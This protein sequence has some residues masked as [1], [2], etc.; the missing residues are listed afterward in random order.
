MRKLAS[1]RS[2]QCGGS[3]QTK[4]GPTPILVMGPPSSSYHEALSNSLSPALDTQ[5]ERSQ[6]MGT[7]Q[8]SGKM[9]GDEEKVRLL[10]LS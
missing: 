8:H 1:E 10:I 7:V 5:Q 6:A 2:E 4:G 3:E 9:K